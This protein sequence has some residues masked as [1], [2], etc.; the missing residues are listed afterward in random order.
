MKI[1]IVGLLRQQ[2]DQIKQRFRDMD[3]VFYPKDCG[4]GKHFAS[5]TNNCDEV[6]LMTKFIDHST[7]HAVDNEK[8]VLVHGG[9]SSLAN[10]LQAMLESHRKS[11][12][13]AETKE[14][15][16]SKNV[17]RDVNVPFDGEKY[18][19]YILKE[20]KVGDRARIVKPTSIDF[21]SWK[22][23]LA[24]MRSNMLRIN[25]IELELAFTS[26]HAIATVT[27]VGGLKRKS[28]V[29][30][31]A[32]PMPAPTAAAEKSTVALTAEQAA[33]WRDVT[34][35]AVRRG[36]SPEA[37]AEVADKLLMLWMERQK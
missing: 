17:V 25:K 4:G 18:Q 5:F 22:Q 30:I 9:L 21:V 26:T 7:F 20:L 32:G 23:R 15:M 34:I 1:G 14:E 27:S 24:V 6:I 2:A 19:W 10:Y 28:E 31:D 33:Y 29:T 8:R 16:D 13:K 12:P 35:A 36:D 11:E 37:A 3:L